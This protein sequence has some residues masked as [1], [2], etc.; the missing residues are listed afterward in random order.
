MKNPFKKPSA[1]IMEQKPKEGLSDVQFVAEMQR[2]IDDYERMFDSI[3]INLT[4][5]VHE[6]HLQNSIRLERK[7]YGHK[8][9]I[10][11]ICYL[12]DNHIDILKEWEKNAKY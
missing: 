6:G 5:G 12:F 9:A 1:P 3:L 4:E 2:K 10:S 11:L 8:A 7:N